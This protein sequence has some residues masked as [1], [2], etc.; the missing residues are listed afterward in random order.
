ME[1][2]YEIVEENID[3]CGTNASVYVASPDVLNPEE[4]LMLKE[5]L[6]NVKSSTLSEDWDTDNM[7]DEALKQFLNKT[8]KKLN[9]TDSPVH[10]IITF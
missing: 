4:E 2:I 6:D 9:I 10:N 8:E 7:V 3:G 5:C 1:H